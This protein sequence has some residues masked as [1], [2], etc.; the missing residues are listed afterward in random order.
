M[1]VEIGLEAAWFDRQLR[2]NSSADES[3][4][5]HEIE[6]TRTENSDN[7]QNQEA[8]IFFMM[9]LFSW[10]DLVLCY[11]HKYILKPYSTGVNEGY[12]LPIEKNISRFIFFFIRGI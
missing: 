4:T 2:N 9:F 5:A 10:L 1:E 6:K 7:I 3:E 8:L 11:T 12:S